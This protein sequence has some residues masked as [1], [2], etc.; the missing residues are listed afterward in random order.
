MEE[1]CWRQKSRALWLKEGDWNTKYFH[2]IVNS[3]HRK[4]SIGN[5]VVDGETIADLM[6]INLRIVDFYRNLFVES[7]VRR[8]TLDAL[9]VLASDG[10]DVVWLEK[11]SLR[12]RSLTL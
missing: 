10:D 2:H 7:G 8:L 3:H 12:W 5:I 6:E 11:L 1:I 9:T 4:S